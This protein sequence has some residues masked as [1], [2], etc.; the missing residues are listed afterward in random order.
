MWCEK[1]AMVY[2][3]KNIHFDWKNGDVVTT[4]KPS[5]NCSNHINADASYISG[6]YVN[7]ANILKIN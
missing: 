2:L 1:V 7:K 3:G 5:S 4:T 6:Y